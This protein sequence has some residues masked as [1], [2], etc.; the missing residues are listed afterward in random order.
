M[1]SC[2]ALLYLTKLVYLLVFKRNVKDWKL[3]VHMK[4]ANSLLNFLAFQAP[5]ELNPELRNQSVTFNS[6]LNLTCIVRGDRPLRINWTKNGVDLGN[7]DN[8]TYTAFQM[9]FDH[10]GLYGCAAENWAGKV[11][12]SFWIDV[13]GK[14]LRAIK[15]IRTMAFF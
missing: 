3:H 4:T 6:T 12:T 7:R 2:Y 11:Y 13:T 5:P 9:T 10:A 8:N 1:F 14:A 15:A